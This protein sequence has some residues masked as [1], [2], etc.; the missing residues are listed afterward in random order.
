MTKL[1]EQNN[2]SIVEIVYYA[3]ALVFAG[4]LC[5][6][7][8]FGRSAGWFYLIVLSLIRILGGCLQLATISSPANVNLLVGAQTLQSIGLSPLI[9]VLLGFVSRIYSA[10]PSNAQP[11]LPNTRVLRLLQ[12]LVM[13]GLILTIVGGVN[14]GDQ[15]SDALAAGQPLQ[16]TVASES[17]GGI[18]CMIAG[19]VLL[20]LSALVLSGSYGRMPYSEQRL[21]LAVGLAAPFVLVRLIYSILVAFSHNPSFR[22]YGGAPDA[23]N[24]VAGMCVAMEFAAVAIFEVAGM[25]IAYVPHKERQ[26]ILPGARTAEAHNLTAYQGHGG[27]Q[28]PKQVETV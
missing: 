28:Y 23:A 3:P 12:I 14:T 7:H 11:A 10:L 27:P 6:R 24:Y 25:S 15:I 26:A 20:L 18:G 22:Q 16:Y 17:K 4:I 21:L 8:G 2:I 13:V 1:T 5:W 9:L 19:F